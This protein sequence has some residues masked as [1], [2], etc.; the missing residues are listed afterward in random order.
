MGAHDPQTNRSFYLSLAASTFRFVI[1]A[2]LVVGGIV[3]INQAF[4]SSPSGTT[5]P[6]D[7]GAGGT[8]ATSPTASPSPTESP[9][10]QRSPTVEGVR[11]AVFNGTGVTGLAGD[12]LARLID[13]FG[14][15]QAQ[16]P[17]DA[18]EPVA[19][20]TI[21][22]RANRDRVEAEFLAESFFPRRLEVRVAKLE[23]GAEVDRSAQLA[24]YVGNDYAQLQG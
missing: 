11:I 13:E 10:E 9:V 24:I 8:G 14:Y 23:A 21:Y 4:P 18:P 16:E 20:T 3:V 19:V 2:A 6:I 1:I 7:G 15:V 17:A 12:T 5:A 22:Y